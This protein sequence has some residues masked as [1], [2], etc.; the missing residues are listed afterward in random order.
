MHTYNKRYIDATAS[1]N[2]WRRSHLARARSCHRHRPVVGSLVQRSTR[3]AY[4]T[5]YVVE[6]ARI[7]ELWSRRWWDVLG[8]G[9]VRVRRNVRP[10]A[11][12]E[13]IHTNGPKCHVVL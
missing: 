10:S 6:F 3:H 4:T 13:H 12:D 11:Q 9:I 7:A 2:I 5:E 8:L 1:D